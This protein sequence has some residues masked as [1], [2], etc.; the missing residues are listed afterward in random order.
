MS[1]VYN[2]DLKFI[3]NILDCVFDTI[4]KGC[5]PTPINELMIP[6]KESLRAAFTVV[7]ADFIQ[8]PIFTCEG[9]FHLAILRDEVL[10]GS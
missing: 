3:I 4:P 6:H 5:V 2:V 8:P 7:A 10:V 9:T 1:V